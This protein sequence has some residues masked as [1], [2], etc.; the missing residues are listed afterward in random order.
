MSKIFNESN[1]F[2]YICNIYKYKYKKRSNSTELFSA[3]HNTAVILFLL[4]DMKKKKKSKL[5][6]YAW[7]GF[8]RCWSSTK[9]LVASRVGRVLPSVAGCWKGCNQ[10]TLMCA[11][12]KT[13]SMPQRTE[14]R[15]AN[16][17][18]DWRT[19]ARG[20]WPKV[21]PFVSLQFLLDTDARIIKTNIYGCGGC[22]LWLPLVRP[23][24]RLV[25]LTF[26]GLSTSLCAC[27]C[28]CWCASL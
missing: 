14:G 27:A 13:I 23:T 9:H 28:V 7:F 4:R 3:R 18:S 24:S 10:L 17:L 26:N 6:Q 25:L 16:C 15:A 8:Q 20:V 22:W 11:R 5:V 12:P 1:V 21:L 2:T 19:D